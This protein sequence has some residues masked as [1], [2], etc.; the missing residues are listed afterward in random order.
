MVL[1][2]TD[3]RIKIAKIHRLGQEP[4]KEKSW[5]GESLKPAFKMSEDT[6][7]NYKATIHK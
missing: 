2:F 5:K 3:M 7:L 1:L 4:L 6:A